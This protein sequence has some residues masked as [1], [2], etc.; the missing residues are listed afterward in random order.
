MS[1]LTLTRTKGRKRWSFSKMSSCCHL[2]WWCRTSDRCSGL[3]QLT[4]STPYCDYVC[5]FDD[6]FCVIMSTEEWHLSQS[7]HMKCFPLDSVPWLWEALLHWCLSLINSE[8]KTCLSST[9]FIW[10]NSERCQEGK[11][12]GKT[13]E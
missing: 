5:I 4:L 6:F 8:D 1:S 9:F 11:E 2:H 12:T 7:V 3:L 13:L 10:F